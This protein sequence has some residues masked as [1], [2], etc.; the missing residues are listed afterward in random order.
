M[1]KVTSI[2][3]V[4]LAT[5]LPNLLGV[6][7]ARAAEI[8]PEGRDYFEAHIR[9]V[10]VAECYDCHAGSKKKGGLVV[11]S[12]DGLL[13]GGENGPSLIPGDAQNSLLIQTLAHTHKDP[14][15][16]MP[17]DGAKLDASALKHFVEWVNMGAPDP[18]DKPAVAEGAQP[19]SWD[20]IFALRKQW[21]S[22]Q[23]VNHNV[24]PPS[25]TAEHPV[26]RFIQARLAEQGL[27]PAP[28]A[29]RHLLIRRLSFALTGLPPKAEEVEKFLADTSPDAW[30]R[31]VDYYLEL[32]T[33]GETWARHWMDLMRYAE[34]H[35]SE[36]DPAIPGAWMYRDY[37]VRAFNSDL[38]YRQF[39]QE[40]IAGDL[41]KPRWNE[42][43]GVNE[44][45]LGSANLRLMEHGFQPVDSLDEQVKTV[46]NQIDVLSKT[47]LGLTVSCARC[48][49]HKFDAISQKDFYALYGILASTRPAQVV[50]DPPA[51][52]DVHRE[53][54]TRLKGQIKAELAGLWLKSAETLP[55]QLL[56]PAGLEGNAGVRGEMEASLADLRS[57]ARAVALARKGS[58]VKDARVS[59]PMACW[60]FEGD[61]R[62]QMGGLDGELV[63]GAVVRNGRLVLNGQDAYVR[64]APLGKAIRARTLEAWVRLD[65]TEQRGG[66]V[67]SIES[68]RG[69]VFDGIVFG[70]KEP[71]EWISGSDFHRRTK[72]VGG[73]VEMTPKDQFVHIAITYSA[74]NV[75]AIYRNGVPYG[76][77]YQSEE[78]IQTYGPG[79]AHLLLG[80][81]HLGG[82]NALLA[83]EIEEAR[84][85]DRALSPAEVAAS[86]Q[87]GTV[88]VPEQELLAAM[89]DREKSEFERL[90]KALKLAEKE[91]EENPT[92]NAWRDALSSAAKNASDALY[93]WAKL[94]DRQGKSFSKVWGDFAATWSRDLDERRRFNA[95]NF[96]TLWDV[97]KG[98]DYSRWFR[99]GTGL[100][101]QPARAGE[102]MV[103]AD[104]NAVVDG[105]LP[106][107]VYSSLLS[108][109]HAGLL[110]SPF[111][112]M[113]TEALSLQ[114]T[115]D[116]GGGVRVM[117]DNYPLGNNNTYPQYRPAAE[118]LRWLKLDTSYRKGAQ[119]Y[120]ELGT[121]DDSTRPQPPSTQAPKKG[122]KPK[123]Y[124]GRSWFGVAGI[125]LNKPG[126][127][128]PPRE[129]PLALT[130]IL[131]SPAPADARG[132]AQ[133][134]GKSLAD[135]VV[136][137]KEGRI[138]P[139]QLAYLNDFVRRGLVPVTADSSPKLAELVRQY[140]KLE[141]EVPVPQRAPGPVEADGYNAPLMVRGDH[142]KPSDLVHRGFLSALGGANCEDQ[143]SGRRQ[144]AAAMTNQENPLLDRVM[145]NRIWYWLFGQGLVGTVDNFG[146]LGDKPT[147]PELL[148]YLATRFEEE[149]GSV[150]QMIRFLLASQT[151]QQSSEAPAETVK[152]DAANQW[153][154]RARVRRL[155]AEMI[156]DAMLRVS[157]AL[158]ETLYG[159]PVGDA[160]KRRSLYLRERR[161]APH[162][163]LEVFDR[164]KPTTTR[165]QRDAT[166]IPAQSL[167]MMNDRFVIDLALV[168]SRQMARP[169]AGATLEAKVATVYATALGRPPTPEEQQVAK[170][171]F[172][173]EDTEAV[174]KDYL[175]AVFALKEFIY[176]R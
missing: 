6:G 93:P 3:S 9:P 172:A 67:V 27:Q 51:K 137:W 77:P 86:F 131:G 144:L 4:L 122:Q 61:A 166:N 118:P 141:A 56:N 2:A 88:A 1:N 49:D 16:H 152:R 98:E 52:L 148:D 107:G 101:P 151:W 83:G 138:S 40:H 37:L 28:S 75:V 113:D 128:D 66:G 19:V 42:A 158:S 135:A 109:R 159:E 54:L 8:T 53:E 163:F 175:Q 89:S 58:V 35:G 65:N 169:E 157:G 36:G 80:R 146:R 72:D 25:G 134:M 29:D 124:D 147:H 12:R 132:L 30:G 44:A 87:V 33:F 47:F 31:L 127:N 104:G 155:E 20:Q 110:V 46:D 156:R 21:W 84:L 91:D 64:T 43:L 68:E 173:G 96:T 5:S 170:D 34:T 119:A 7:S 59:D 78:E 168:W 171:Y 70:E 161:T 23:P 63:G 85:Y 81:R 167:T 13:K 97:S 142:L 106:A 162:A 11:D 143:G 22:L 120:V 24:V 76:Q 60:N 112:K 73:P 139:E 117:V 62:D 115:G 79:G 18:R 90:T 17:K 74:D 114:L 145:V 153:F 154:S 149:G 103:Q 108:A 121:R 14:D 95:E 48:H 164:P 82:G 140:R 32:P 126:V 125:V 130:G 94:K 99:K 92:R 133:L 160:Q 116:E 39:V 102:F 38:P 174:W 136:A 150:K 165:G 69:D 50:L 100:P 10:L 15:L 45:L 129:L 71:R 41:L 176:L 111:F 55:A 26:D 105:L 57:R 123:E